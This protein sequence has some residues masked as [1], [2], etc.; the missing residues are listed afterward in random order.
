MSKARPGIEVFCS[1][2]QEDAIWLRK[3]EAHLSLLKQQ[4]SISLWHPRLLVAGTDC[5]REIDK[6]L[7]TASIILLLVSADFLNSDYCYGVKMQHALARHAAGEARVIP[8][9]LRPIDY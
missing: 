2:A 6:H 8:I 4:G 7:N 5:H 3:L 1:S 9:L